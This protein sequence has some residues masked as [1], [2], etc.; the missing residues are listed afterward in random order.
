[1][2]VPNC[3]AVSSALPTPLIT[4]LLFSIAITSGCLLV[5]VTGK[6]ES[7]VA[8]VGITLLNAYN[9]SGG[10]L[11]AM[12]CIRRDSPTIIIFSGED[13]SL[14]WI[15]KLKAVKALVVGEKFTLNG[16]DSLGARLVFG[17]S[18]REMREDIWGIVI[19]KPLRSAWPVFF[20]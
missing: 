18:P 15:S 19:A 12:F 20:I 4:A 7:A 10:W 6:P 13:V 14:L 3:E 2:G 9:W 17:R 1:M 8:V 11:K 5:R 16:I